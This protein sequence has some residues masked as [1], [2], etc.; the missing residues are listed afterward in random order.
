MRLH[1]LGR[2]SWWLSIAV[3]ASAGIAVV[4]FLTIAWPWGLFV[5]PVLMLWTA[6]LGRL[7]G[8]RRSKREYLSL[9]A[10]TGLTVLVLVAVSGGLLGVISG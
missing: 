10:L 4:A 5:A 8:K 1:A 6:L 3:G 7:I 9:F 2:P